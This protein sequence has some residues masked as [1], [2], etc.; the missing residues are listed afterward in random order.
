MLQLA[1]LPTSSHSSDTSNA[2]LIFASRLWLTLSTLLNILPSEALTSVPRAWLVEKAPT[3][4]LR[5]FQQEQEGVADCCA[6]CHR[7]G[8]QQI[9]DRHQH[10][11]VSEF[12]VRVL[13]LLRET[14]WRG[15]ENTG[16]GEQ[17]PSTAGLGV[18]H[19]KSVSEFK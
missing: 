14:R 19:S 18:R 13:F 16:C 8:E 5:V 4:D 17:R 15:S 11:L 10:V 2:G 12:R 7:P 9:S 3:L 1:V 6:H